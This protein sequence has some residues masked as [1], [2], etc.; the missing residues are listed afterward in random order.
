MANKKFLA[1]K[2]RL[3]GVVK[4]EGI[5]GVTPNGKVQRFVTSEIFRRLI[6]YIPVKSGVLQDSAR[7]TDSTHIRV[8]TPYA[9]AQFFGVT[10]SGKPFNYNL[11]GSPKAGSHWDRRL[12]A[13]EGEQIVQEANDF[14]KSGKAKGT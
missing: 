2:T 12:V 4:A 14:V 1:V 8:D 13:D 9:R 7:I 10:K 6:D 3:P 11:A 5:L